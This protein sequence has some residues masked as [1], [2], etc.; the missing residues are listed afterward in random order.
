M[1]LLRFFVYFALWFCCCW[2]LLVFFF[3]TERIVCYSLSQQAQQATF[4]PYSPSCHIPDLCRWGDSLPP[5]SPS[6]QPFSSAGGIHFSWGSFPAMPQHL[7]SANFSSWMNA[8]QQGFQKCLEACFTMPCQHSIISL[9]AGI[10]PVQETLQMSCRTS[11][12]KETHWKSFS[13]TEAV[14]AAGPTC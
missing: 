9:W 1:G 12:L 10:S 7:P 3:Y 6:L 8:G 5:P 2:V 14:R 11:A 4:S 13:R